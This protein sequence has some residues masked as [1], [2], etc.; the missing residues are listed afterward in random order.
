MSLI[1]NS[2][3]SV[4]IQGQSGVCLPCP[5]TARYCWN[6]QRG[7]RNPVRWIPDNVSAFGLNCLFPYY[8]HTTKELGLYWTVVTLYKTL[9]PQTTWRR[10]VLA[11]FAWRKQGDAVLAVLP[12][13]LSSKLLW[14]ILWTISSTPVCAGLILRPSSI[15]FDRG[16]ITEISLACC[17]L[18][19]RQ[20]T[21]VLAAQ[22]HS[23]VFLPPFVWRFLWGDQGGTALHRNWHIP[24]LS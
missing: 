4:S 7:G 13:F 2:V 15:S 23:T 3:V 16:R 14:T 1:F 5:N 8:H 12:N 11:P 9:K 22:T 18:R 21:S 19:V 17:L 24:A 10:G 20:L 6:E